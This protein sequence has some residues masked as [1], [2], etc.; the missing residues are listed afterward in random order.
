MRSK[1]NCRAAM[2]APRILEKIIDIASSDSSEDP[3]EQSENDSD[4]NSKSNPS[5]TNHQSTV[6][7][8]PIDEE[9]NDNSKF[10]PG[11]LSERKISAP[12]KPRNSDST[13]CTN[14]KGDLNGDIDVII[15]LS[16][17]TSASTGGGKDCTLLVQVNPEDTPALDFHGA[18]GAVGRFEANENEVSMDLKG[19]QYQGMILPGPTALVVSMHPKMGNKIAK[20][21]SITDEFMTIKQASD[22]MAQLD[23]VVEKGDMDST[24]QVR[25][26]NVNSKDSKTDPDF[27]REIQCNSRGKKRSSNIKEMKRGTKKLK[28]IDSKSTSMVRSADQKKGRN[29]KKVKSR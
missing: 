6:S 25:D 7:R 14:K 3:T 15:P 10:D 28:T 18:S 1:R 2:S 23:A 21:E 29:K 19:Y 13:P 4:D 9:N 24:Y 5:K 8:V 20:V 12:V 17:L 16:L 11:C 27:E 26:E 22:T